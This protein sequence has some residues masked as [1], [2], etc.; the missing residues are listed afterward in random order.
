MEAGPFE[1]ALRGKAVSKMET[2]TILVM[3]TAVTFVI[4]GVMMATSLSFVNSDFDS[5]MKIAIGLITTFAFI[6]G[7]IVMWGSAGKLHDGV[8]DMEV[9]KIPKE[10]LK[11]MLGLLIGGFLPLVAVLVMISIEG[12]DKLDETVSEDRKDDYEAVVY[13]GVAAL[14]AGLALWLAFLIFGTDTVA[15]RKIKAAM[16]AFSEAQG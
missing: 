7:L 14:G 15:H 1:R 4:A 2:V 16:R 8:E 12:L 3:L 13:T 5:D 11:L 9:G 6:S 10:T